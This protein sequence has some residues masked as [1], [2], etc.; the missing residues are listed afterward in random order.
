MVICVRSVSVF[1]S[2][3]GDVLRIREMKSYQLKTEE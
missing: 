3:V 1:P 2:A